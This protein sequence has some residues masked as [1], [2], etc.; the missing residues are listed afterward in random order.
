M[1]KPDCWLYEEYDTNGEL[2]SSQI[3]TFLP[4]DLKQTIKLKDVHHVELTPMYKDIKKYLKEHFRH[5]MKTVSFLL[6]H[7]HG[8]DQAP[9]E[10]I[11]EE[12]YLEMTKNV[13][14]ITSVEVKESEMELAECEGGYCPVK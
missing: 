13:K 3:W 2:R 9:Y 14:P 5:E 8:F 12:Q 11:T 1:K 4:S 7:G 10:T 6:Y